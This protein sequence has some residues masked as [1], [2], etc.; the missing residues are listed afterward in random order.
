MEQIPLALLLR[1]DRRAAD[2]VARAVDAVARLGLLVTGQ[3]RASISARA[4]EQRCAELFGRTPLRQAGEP[5]AGGDAGRPPGFAG[6]GS[7]PVPP[8]LGEFVVEITVSAPAY[9]LD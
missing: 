5:A 2:D 3:G 4:S 6:T 1:P 9:R 8:E 7:L